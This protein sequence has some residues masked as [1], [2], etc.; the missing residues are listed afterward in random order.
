MTLERFKAATGAN[1]THVPYRGGGAMMPDLISGTVNGAMTEFSTAMAL[2][3]GGK[4]HIVA[5]PRPN[6]DAGARNPDLHRKRREGLH[7]AELY[8]HRRAREDPAG[9]RRGIAAG[10]CRGPAERTGAG[11]AASAW[12]RK[13]PRPSR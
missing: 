8:R 13:S 5:W 2:H 1:I 9:Y 10:G 7:R 4:A 11:T 6:V 3:K 12:A